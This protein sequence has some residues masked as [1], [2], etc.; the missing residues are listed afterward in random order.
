MKLKE[1]EGF[2]HGLKDM[3]FADKLESVIEIHRADFFELS[4]FTMHME[5]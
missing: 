2:S 1:K 3:I 5:K 4:N